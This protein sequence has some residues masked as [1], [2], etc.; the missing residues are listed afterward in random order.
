VLDDLH[1]NALR[2][3]RVKAAARR[4]IEQHFGAND[5]AAIVVTSGRSDVG[6]EFTNNRRLLL[7]AIDRFMGQKIR[8]STLDRLDEYSRTRGMDEEARRIKDPNI[9]QREHYARNALE[10]LEKLADFLAGVHGRRKALLFISEGIDYD[11]TNPI[12]N[13]GTTTIL[14]RT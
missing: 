13:H 5:L 12:E 3:A 7:A 1:I 2:S 10:S 6:Q 8:S 4:F 14:A 11:I 9:M